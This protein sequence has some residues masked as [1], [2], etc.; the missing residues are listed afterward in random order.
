MRQEMKI[1]VITILLLAVNVCVYAYVEFMGSSYDTAFMLDMGASYEPYII[2]NHEYYR[3]VTH[4][5]LHYGFDHLFNNMVSLLILG[6]SLESIL[7]KGRYA[8]IY[9]LSG[10]LAGISSVVYTW[11]LVSPEEAAVSCGASGAVYGLMGALL[12]L[13]IKGGKGQD[14]TQIPRYILFLGLSLYSGIQDTSIDN[15]AHVGGFLAGFVICLIMC[16]K[17]RMEV[18]YES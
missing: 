16:R 1:P 9:F 3:L 7:G 5:F 4:F 18:N 11:L 17:K 10:I 2:E 15:A 13:L 12:V 14:R 6:Y 8:V